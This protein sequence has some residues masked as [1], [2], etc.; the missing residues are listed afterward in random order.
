MIFPILS[1]LFLD[2]ERP[3]HAMVL[4]GDIQ[5]KWWLFYIFYK[6]VRLGNVPL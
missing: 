2:L 6:N 1:E 4:I 5:K 3:W